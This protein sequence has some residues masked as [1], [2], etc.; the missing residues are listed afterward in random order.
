MDLILLSAGKGSRLSKKLRSNP[1]SLVKVNNKAIIDYN[2]KFY[3]KFKKKIIITGYKK[4]S[5][6]NFAK[7]NKFKII[8][9]FNYRITNMVYS[10][11]LA[12]KFIKNDVVICYGDIIFD[13]KIHNLLIE[14]KSLIPLNL[15][16][17][18]IWK[19]RMNKKDIINDAENLSINKNYLA[20]IGGKITNKYP[21]YQYM[22]IFK[23]KKKDYFKL[24]HYFKKI[25]NPKI[26]MTT[27][28]DMAIKNTKIKLRIKAYKSFW[29]EIDND[30]DLFI[31]SKELKNN[32]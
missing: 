20:S 24:H 18:N 26:D 6:S 32:I 28:L 16:W 21:K 29:Y 22:G 3:E 31:T 12:S 17:L 7:K 2:L 23:L 25:S 1:K 10:M 8:N 11:F 19:K 5:F 15:N 13:D 4:R 27:F 9:N 30:R 14:K